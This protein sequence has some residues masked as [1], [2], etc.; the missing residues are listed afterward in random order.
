MP[1]MAIF[2]VRPPT[3]SL[4][5]AVTALTPGLEER[6]LLEGAP[7]EREVA[8]LLLI[9]KA[10]HGAV[11]QVDGRGFALN[12]DFGGDGADLHAE[13]DDGVLA[14]FEADGRAGDRL[15]SGRTRADPVPAR[16]RSRRPP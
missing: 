10:A 8:H 5:P 14:D 12:L 11:D 7:V 1:L 13:I 2:G 3:G 6:E 4:P 16:R 9:D 15:E